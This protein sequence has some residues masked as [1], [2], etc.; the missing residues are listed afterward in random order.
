M[1]D[2]AKVITINAPQEMLAATPKKNVKKSSV[3]KLVLVSL[4]GLVVAGALFG[5]GFAVGR[6]TA[7]HE[8]DHPAEGVA[9]NAEL[10]SIME[11]EMDK[12][13]AEEKAT[14]ADHSAPRYI[15]PD[16]PTVWHEG[17]EFENQVIVK[18]MDDSVVLDMDMDLPE[19]MMPERY[20]GADAPKN[21]MA[22]QLSVKGGHATLSVGGRNI[23]AVPVFPTQRRRK[24]Q[25]TGKPSDPLHL[26]FEIDAS[27]MSMS[28]AALCD[29]LNNDSSVEIAYLAPMPPEMPTLT[30]SDDQHRTLQVIRR[31]LASKTELR[32]L[33]S[34][35]FT[36]LQGYRGPAPNG[37]D[38]DVAEEYAAGLGAGITV[39]DIEGGG[40]L[41]HEDLGMQG[42]EQINS[43]STDPKWVA[44]GTAVWGE[45]KGKD[46]SQG[47]RGGAVAVTPIVA[48]IFG[49][50]GVAA[51]I[52]QTADRL[53]AGDVMLIELQYR[54]SHAGIDATY[55]PVEYYPAQWAAIRAA[56][57]KG[58]VVIEAGANG[59]MDLDAVQGGRFKRG[60]ANFLPTRALSWWAAG[61]P[62]SARG[63]AP[64][65]ALASAAASTCR[66]GTIQLRRRATGA[67]A[68][69]GATTMRTP[70]S[71]RARRRRA[72]SSPPPLLSCSRWRS[73]RSGACSSPTSSGR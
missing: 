50:Q 3:V 61:V 14:M 48:S 47:V 71:S 18:L 70:V 35:S 51:V 45:I 64:C 11:E 43:I 69:A 9:K 15:K 20:A 36:H 40:N 68:A 29:Q 26:F 58:I 55:C 6:E 21:R 13:A 2:T 38:F 27:N 65:S 23:N 60:H 67:F 54:F 17:M 57:D 7:E 59:H 4:A 73:N 42:A 53:Q 22:R 12:T 1:T 41:D 52:H 16:Q 8:Q 10:T 49:G 28:G 37:F 39:A 62:I 34:P 25:A 30:S 32:R 19:P 31:A 24:L 33:L 44:H 56:V 72:R 63:S 5:S 66:V 46:D